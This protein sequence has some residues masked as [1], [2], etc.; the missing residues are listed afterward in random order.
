MEPFYVF[1]RHNQPVYEHPLEETLNVCLDALYRD[2]DICKRPQPEKLLR[3]M[4]LKATTEVE[5]SFEGTIYWQIDGV[6]MVSPLVPTLANIFVG[7]C[8]SRLQADKW[9]LLYNCFVDDTFSIFETE[10]RADE[11]FRVLNSMHPAL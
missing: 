4:L 7:Y 6:A 5:F 9:P 11:F 8:E 3:K 1:V 2:P 10:E